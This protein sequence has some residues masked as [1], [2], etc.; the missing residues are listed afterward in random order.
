LGTSRF[1]VVKRKITS[2]IKW[3][4]YLGTT[5]C[6]LTSNPLLFGGVTIMLILQAMFTYLPAM[7]LMFRSSPI[8]FWVWGRILA[9]SVTASFVVGVK[10]WLRRR[11]EEKRTVQH[12]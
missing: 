7:N 12:T 1:N 6:R 10:K 3:N 8:S 5:P 9:V 2:F 11:S 4:T